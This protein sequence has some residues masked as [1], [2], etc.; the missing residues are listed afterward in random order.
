MKNR[1]DVN[2]ESALPLFGREIEESAIY[3]P[4]GGMHEHVHRAKLRFRLTHTARG[5][6]GFA[7]V[8]LD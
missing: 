7:T 3:R 1:V 2:V 4:T 6:I 5:V 8:G